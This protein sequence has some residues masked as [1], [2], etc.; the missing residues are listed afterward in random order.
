MK[1]ELTNNQKDQLLEIKRGLKTLSNS[2]DA[3]ETTMVAP[4]VEYKH[5]EEKCLNIIDTLSKLLIAKDNLYSILQSVT[6]IE[7]V[8]N[9]VNDI[10]HEKT[11]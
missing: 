8:E 9:L 2:I 7:N 4:K 10:I 1:L 11:K 3:L 6:D 5:V